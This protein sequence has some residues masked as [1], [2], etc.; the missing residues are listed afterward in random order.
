MNRRELVFGPGP[1]EEEDGFERLMFYVATVLI[2]A[3]AVAVPLLGLLAMWAL[4]QSVG[5]IGLLL[6]VAVLA[7][8]RVGLAIMIKSDLL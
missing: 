6:P 8:Y 2:G 1:S 3:L 7:V 4:V 5:L